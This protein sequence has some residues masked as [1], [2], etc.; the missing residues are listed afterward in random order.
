MVEDTRLAG[1]ELL[2]LYGEEDSEMLGAFPFS[3]PKGLSKLARKLPVFS[4]AKGIKK[5]AKYTPAYQ[6]YKGSKK[7]KKAIKKRLHGE[8]D[9]IGFFYG[10]DDRIGAEVVSFEVSPELLGAVKKTAKK[11]AVKKA[12]KKTGQKIFTGIKKV[13]KVTSGFTSAAARAV[14]V[15]AP[16][17]KA[18]SKIDPT[19]GKKASAAKAIEAY[20]EETGK[21]VIPVKAEAMAMDTKKIAIIAGSG[22]GA[23]IVLKLLLSAPRRA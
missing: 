21:E 19:K 23:L 13:G 12:K 22:L 20:T 7:A 18:L 17:L 11:P 2:A 15:P 9:R 5:A 8:D 3:F 6:I 1:A 16:L 4:V 10:D 14:G